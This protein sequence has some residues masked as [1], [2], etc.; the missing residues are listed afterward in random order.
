MPAAARATRTI[1]SSPKATRSSRCL[2]AVGLLDS[3][4]LVEGSGRRR[5]RAGAGTLDRHQI[6]LDRTTRIHQLRPQHIIGD[7]LS[8]RERAEAMAVLDES[9]HGLLEALVRGPLV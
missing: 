3:V 7:P 1:A 8:R 5:R 4:G 6:L 2:D 9:A